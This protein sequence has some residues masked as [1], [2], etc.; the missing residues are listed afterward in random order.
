MRFVIHKNFYQFVE[1]KLRINFFFC[2]HSSTARH[3]RAATSQSERSANSPA[4]QQRSHVVT[5]ALLAAASAEPLR[6]PA[7][8]PAT[9]RVRCHAGFHGDAAAASTDE[10]AAS[11]CQP[12]ADTRVQS[13]DAGQRPDG[14]KPP[15]HRQSV[16]ASPAVNTTAPSRSPT[17]PAASH[18]SDG[19]RFPATNI[20]QSGEQPQQF[21]SRHFHRRQPIDHFLLCGPRHLVHH[22]GCRR[23]LPIP[24][25]TAEVRLADGKEIEF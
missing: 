3:Q 22:R 16:G 13:P 10:H 25:A 9:R 23:Q 20:R 8:S 5:A 21:V 14:G 18:G 19:P 4:E 11:H 2:H 15:F 17:A 6:L 12:P 7:T 24:Q 1:V